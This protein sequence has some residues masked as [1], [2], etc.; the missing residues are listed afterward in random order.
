[1]DKA[2]TRLY[3]EPRKDGCLGRDMGETGRHQWNEE[4]RLQ[5]ATVSE[6]GEDIQW[7]LWETIELENTHTHKK[8]SS[9]KIKT[10]SART[11]WRVWPH[12]KQKKRPLTTD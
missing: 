8:G 7:D 6:E 5:G 9:V 1:M 11:L 3:Q 2:M 10:I 12:L 4:P